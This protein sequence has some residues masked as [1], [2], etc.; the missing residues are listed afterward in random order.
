MNS[1]LLCCGHCLEL[2]LKW[3]APSSANRFDR[4]QDN[5]IAAEIDDNAVVGE[6]ADTALDFDV[7][8]LT[9]AGEVIDFAD[10]MMEITA[11]T[12]IRDVKQ[13]LSAKIP[14]SMYCISLLRDVE[15]LRNT[16]LLSDLE[17]ECGVLQLT[18][19]RSPHCDESC[20]ELLSCAQQAHARVSAVEALL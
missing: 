16:C 8:I 2:I 18:A 13:S 17:H 10:V 3:N 9:P 7:Q 1:S 4:I 5:D 12:T 15:E 11:K 14:C 6:D 20:K 19:L